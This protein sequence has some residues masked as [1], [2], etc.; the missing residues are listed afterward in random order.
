[1]AAAESI[2]DLAISEDQVGQS[3]QDSCDKKSAID[4]HQQQGANY[5]QDV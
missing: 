2:L 4:Y 3:K 1:L 5:S